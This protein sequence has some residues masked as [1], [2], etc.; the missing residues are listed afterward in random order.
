MTVMTAGGP[1]D[2]SALGPTL[3]H[4]HLYS[5]YADYRT[6][7]GWD[8]DESIRTAQ[9]VLA[10][11][12]TTGIRTIVEMSV[13][14]MGRSAHRLRKIAEGHPG[15][16]IIAATGIFTFGDMPNFFRTRL[17][18]VDENWMAD[19]FAREITEG[20]GDSGV[21]AGVIKFVTDKQ[22]AN[23]DVQTIAR[24]VARAQLAT[25]VPI[26][27]HSHS[28]SQSGL[29][30]QDMFRREGVDLARVV[31]GHAG[32]SADLDYLERLIDNGSWLG[33]DRFGHGYSAPLEQRIDT[34]A[35]MCARGHANRMVLSHDANI[36]SDSVPPE[37]H[38]AQEIEHWNFRT[39]SE[40][41]LPSLRERG[42]SDADIE[43]MMVHNP[44]AVLE[45]SA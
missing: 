2:G 36:T 25:G 29:V 12:A 15:V 9:S 34:V 10:D 42:V 6:D 22:G 32:D 11:L 37:V 13:L 30:Q 27:T 1:I 39:I 40:I 45:F 7:Y 44:R 26:I 17:N 28:P 5:L 21:R 35:K 31:I 3:I 43:L 4:E 20:I 19:F 14:G 38:D 41:V 23:E 18:L 24:Q 8:E 16:N 33:M